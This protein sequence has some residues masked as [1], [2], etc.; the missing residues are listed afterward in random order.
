MVRELGWT[1]DQV[2]VTGGESGYRYSALAE[3]YYGTGL[4]QEGEGRARLAAIRK[5]EVLSAGKIL[6]IRQHYFLDQKDV[7]FDTDAA[8]ASSAKPSSHKRFP[9]KRS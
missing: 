9:K 5:Q 7:G 2:I 8:T 6:G 1:A 4:T 3:V